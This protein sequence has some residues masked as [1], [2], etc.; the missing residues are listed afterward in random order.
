MQHPSNIEFTNEVDLRTVTR[1]ILVFYGILN[2]DFISHAV[3]P[4]CVNSYLTLYHRAISWATSQ[5]FIQYR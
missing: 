5:P 2:I 4:F 1:L 3:P